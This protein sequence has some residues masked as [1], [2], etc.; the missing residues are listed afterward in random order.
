MSKNKGS[1]K[2]AKQTTTKQNRNKKTVKLTNN[3]SRRYQRSRAPVAFSFAMG[4][5]SQISNTRSGPLLHFRE[6]FP[7]NGVA[8]GLALALPY[9]PTKWGGTRTA[10]LAAQYSSYRPLTCNIKWQPA[11]GTS[12]AGSI[13]I[14]TIFDG[15]RLTGSTFS[16]FAQSLPATNGGFVGT[17]WQ[18]RASQIMLGRNLRANAYPTMQ[19]SEDEIPFWIVV[20]TDSDKANLGFIV[21]EST[22]TLRNPLNVLTDPPTTFT[23]QTTITHDDQNNTTTMTIPQAEMNKTP[24]VGASYS[25]G[26]FDRLLNVAGGVVSPILNP[27]IATVKSVLDGKVTFSLDNAIATQN[28]MS[29]I[30]GLTSNF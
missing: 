16:Q 24:V 30:I 2:G 27:V 29:T 10:S 22:M 14:G 9:S 23:G 5:F 20:A 6:I 19:I 18:R 17:L 21:I 26:F 1:R 28:V 15:A 3:S 13:A 11:V 12:Q 4:S 25:F 8:S 7:V